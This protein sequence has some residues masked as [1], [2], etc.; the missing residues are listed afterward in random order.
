MVAVVPPHRD[1]DADIVFLARDE[2]RFGHDR[3]FRAVE[4]FHEFL[5]AA[6]IEKLGPQRFGRAFISQDD[7][8]AGVQ[9]RQFAQTFFQRLEAIV[10]VRKRLGRGHEPDFGAGAFGGAHDL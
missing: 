1:F 4:V 9:E 2:N 10:E 7:A 3:G 5:H 6:F 8:H